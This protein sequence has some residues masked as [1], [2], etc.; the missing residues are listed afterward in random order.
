MEALAWLAAAN[1]EGEAGL[2]QPYPTQTGDPETYK[3]KT[4]GQVLQLLAAELQASNTDIA[5]TLATEQVFETGFD[6]LS[7]GFRQA[8]P[9]KIF[10]QWTEVL[11]TDQ[12]VAVEVTYDPKTGQQL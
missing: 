1:V 11:P 2:D 3:N 7:G 9:Y 4:I 6:P 8:E 12:V 5:N 10:D